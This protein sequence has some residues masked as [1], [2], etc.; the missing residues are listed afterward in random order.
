MRPMPT[1]SNEGEPTS[2]YAEDG[3]ADA[4]A[5]SHAPLDA[6]LRSTIDD[7]IAHGLEL[8]AMDRASA[9]SKIVAA[10]AGF[11][12]DV[13]N[14]TRKLTGKKRHALMAL[15]SLYGEALHRALGFTFALV[16]DAGGG[17]GVACIAPDRS[18]AVYVLMLLER[19][20]EPGADT[21]AVTRIYDRLVANESPPGALP[22][23]YAAVT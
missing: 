1:A 14:G 4:L 9:P 16:K 11:A 12:D 7:F 15:G 3:S 19:L 22:H 20:L 18:V 23:A 5:P 2:R 21:T 17:G 8:V 10:I 6:E 13:Q